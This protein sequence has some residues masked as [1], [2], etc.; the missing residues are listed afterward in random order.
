MNKQIS[1]MKVKI[2]LPIKSHLIDSQ[3]NKNA[4]LISVRAVLAQHLSNLTVTRGG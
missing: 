4:T 3:T 2:K 1:V